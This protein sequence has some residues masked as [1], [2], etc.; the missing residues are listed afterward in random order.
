MLRRCQCRYKDATKECT[1]ALSLAP[2][3]GKALL[4][5]AYSYEKQGFYKQALSDIQVSNRGLQ[6]PLEMDMLLLSTCRGS[7]LIAVPVSVI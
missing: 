7:K 3:S 1:S 5:R 2:T 4:R 6:S